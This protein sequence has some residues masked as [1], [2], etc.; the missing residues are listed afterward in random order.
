MHLKK[1]ALILAMVLLAGSL[2]PLLLTLPLDNAQAAA[3][4]PSK[5]V[6]Y[7]SNPVISQGG[8]GAWDSKYLSV[9]NAINDSGT[10]K[11]YYV[12]G[13]TAYMPASL[14]YATSTDG[15]SWTKYGSNPVLSAGSSGAWDATLVSTC[16]VLIDGGTYK[17]WY[18]GYNGV[19]Y[20]IGYATSSDGN[21]W[22]RYASNPVMGLGAA[23]SFD[24]K[25]VGAPYVLK[26]NDE[27]KMWYAGYNGNNWQTG[28]ANSTDGINW[29]KYDNNPVVKVGAANSWDDVSIGHISLAN[30]SGNFHL[31]YG[32]D[33]GAGWGIGYAYSSDGLSWTKYANNPVMSRVANTWERQS[34]LDPTVIY[35]GTGYQMWYNGVTDATTPWTYYIGYAEGL[36]TVPDA[37]TITAPSDAVW[38]NNSKPQFTWTFKDTNS[39]DSQTAC[40]LQLDDD[41]AFGSVNY[42]TGKVYSASSSYTP[43]AAFSDGIYYYR[44]KVWD[45]DDDSGP[46]CTSRTVKIDTT[47][48]NNPGSLSSSSHTLGVWSNDTTLDASF[49]G[50][51]DLLSGLGGYSVVWDYSSTTVPDTVKELAGNAASHTSPAMSDSN[52]VYFHIRAI[53]NASNAAAGAISLGPFNIDAS[54]PTNPTVTSGTHAAGVWT[55]LSV[56]VVNWSGADGTISGLNGFSY[57][58]DN[59]A[60]TVPDTVKECNASADNA[61]SPGLADGAWYF[62]IRSRDEAGNWAA[63]AGHFGPLRID[64]TPPFNP[65]TMTSDHAPSV[66]SNDNTVDVLWSGYDGAVSGV[67]GFSCSWDTSPD[68]LPDGSI[69]CNGTVTNAT[70]PALADGTGHYFHVRA[71]DSAGNWNASAAHFGPLWID[72]TP[73]ANPVA[74]TSGSHRVQSWSNDTTI[75]VGWSTAD[76]GGRISGYEG[77]SIVWDISPLTVPDMTLDLDA[78]V[79]MA[80]S[81]A[82]PDSDGMYFHVR[83]RDRAGNWAQDAAHLGP[84]WIDS[85]PPKNPSSVGSPTHMVEKW[86]ADNTVDMNWSAADASICGVDGYSFVWDTSPLTLPPEAVN[87]TGDIL[88]AAS[89]PLADGKGWYFHLRTRDRAGNWAPNAVHRGPYFIDTTPPRLLGLAIDSGAP[90]TTSPTVRLTISSV[91]PAP[92]SGLAQRRHRVDDGDWSAWEDYSES[93]TLTMN[94]SDGDRTVQVQIRDRVENACPSSSATIMLDTRAPTGVGILINGGINWTN[95]TS[96]VLNVAADDAVPGSGLGEIALGQDGAAWDPWE[97]FSVLRPYNLSAGDGMKTV[98]IRVRDR[99]GNV[100]SFA[101]D[102]IL[103][104]TVRPGSLSLTIAGGAAF[105]ANATVILQPQATDPE[106]ASGIGEMALSEDGLVWTNWEPYRGARAFTFTPG[107]GT[108]I[109]YLRVRDRALND[110]GPVSDTILLDTTPPSIG[111]IQVSGISQSIAV[112]SWYTDEPSNGQVEYGT[113]ISYGSTLADAAY[114][115]QHGLTLTGLL[116]S[117][118]YHLR[119][120]GRDV[121]G[122]GPA[123]SPDIVFRTLKREDKKAP[124]IS[125]VRVDGLTD[126]TALVRWET[127]EPAD[128]AVEYGL[129]RSLGQMAANAS[130]VQSHCV[131][132]AGLSPGT[133]HYFVARS[134]DPSGNGPGSSAILT[135]ATSDKR[136][137]SPPAVRE[138]TV[139]GITDALAIV[140]W[141]TDEPADGR[142]EFG[143]GQNYTRTVTS[144]RLEI[145]H[146]ALVTG[147]LPK[148][149]YHFRVGSSDQSG[150]GPAY[151]DDS[152]FTTASVRDSTPPAIRDTRIVSTGRDNVTIEVTLDEP[153]FVLVEYGAGR[154]YG[155]NAASE[156][157]RAVHRISLPGLEAGTTYHYRVLATDPSGNGPSAGP[158]QKFQTRA[159]PVAQ[160][161]FLTLE[162]APYMFLVIAIMAAAVTFAAYR[163]RRRS[164]ASREAVPEERRPRPEPQAPPAIA[165]AII[166]ASRGDVTGVPPVPPPEATEDAAETIEMKAPGRIQV[167]S[168]VST[169]DLEEDELPEPGPEPRVPAPAQPRAGTGGRPS[170]GDI[171]KALSSLPRGL[172]STLWGMELEELASAVSSGEY[173]QTA[174]GD[175]LVRV[176]NR[177]YFGNHKDIGTYLQQYKGK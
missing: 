102:D 110:A 105:A 49:S 67:A 9:C 73:P 6:R 175:V 47:P 135:F 125:N 112:A 23:G 142:V 17:M 74:L 176:G 83:A 66:W 79:T 52:S 5:W 43:A 26:E 33:S 119:V 146:S 123:F 106:P 89:Q 94:G 40:Q 21:S 46:W 29:T 58:W 107:D 92:A 143:P 77:F 71:L 18:S 97:P 20:K 4:S 108:R 120:S 162:S 155:K 152:V 8:A 174:G 96:V 124:V 156:Q 63:G 164:S 114:S 25:M 80:T 87:V 51:S 127:D 57:L 32:G 163:M 55:N 38:T 1:R 62:H 139:T 116:A 161:G 151:S 141:T 15:K 90:C 50:A 136:D 44:A 170:E 86:N 68:T 82:M 160:T 75:D 31:W 121:Y 167:V 147:L 144:G 11:L 37:P 78:N 91:D 149:Q 48:P 172:P 126:R 19:A 76:G 165:P 81:P 88:G 153:G 85:S 28:F 64:A 104:D 138:V 168:R 42:D 132:L 158:D 53:D 103:L 128:S 14:G 131:R 65:V 7:A 150:N 61:T 100:G 56:C 54:P 159:A 93:W 99:A 166:A 72:S 173:R 177:W 12:G 60:A 117:T 129:T 70:S 27:Y 137:G 3:A 59:G 24:S 69:S 169:G 118:E 111:L 22:T 115:A 39:Q 98:Y 148:T 145:A 154:S 134:K 35:N 13:S 41:S 133:L 2:M 45:S 34:N 95:A 30:V 130:F 171:L 113:T 122:N 109:L 36:N 16:A 84:F 10:L 140:S 157:F 101:A